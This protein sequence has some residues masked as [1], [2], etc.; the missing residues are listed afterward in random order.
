[1]QHLLGKA[2]S[3]SLLPKQFRPVNKAAAGAGKLGARFVN[4]HATSHH[5]RRTMPVA[6]A[7]I[8]RSSETPTSFAATTHIQLQQPKYLAVY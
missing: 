4:T 7:P 1:M 2:P 6:G 5:G 8:I 3:S